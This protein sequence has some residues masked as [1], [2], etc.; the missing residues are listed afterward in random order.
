MKAALLE[1]GFAHGI[2]KHV[3]LVRFY[4]KNGTFAERLFHHIDGFIPG[5]V[6]PHAQYLGPYISKKYTKS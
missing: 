1:F 4:D 6:P 2:D 3:T 5:T